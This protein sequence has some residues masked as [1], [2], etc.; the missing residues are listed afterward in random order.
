M[1]HR[2]R[3]VSISTGIITTLAGNG[4]SSYSGDYG[5]ATAAAL[6]SPYGIALDKKGTLLRGS[7]LPSLINL[8]CPPR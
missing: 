3:K 8:I 5:P 2:I 6:H 4:T 1:N 7:L